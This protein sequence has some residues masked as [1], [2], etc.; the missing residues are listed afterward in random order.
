SKKSVVAK[1]LYHHRLTLIKV[2]PRN[3]QPLSLDT[4][5]DDQETLTSGKLPIYTGKQ[6]ESSK[7]KSRKKLMQGSR[8]YTTLTFAPDVSALKIKDSRGLGNSVGFNLQYFIHPNISIN[9]GA[10]YVFKTY[11]AGEAY[12][13]GYVPSPNH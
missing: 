10:M 8:F 12:S 9:A 1:P 7:P 13:T 11:Q 3:I 4:L 5:T 2:S 6:N